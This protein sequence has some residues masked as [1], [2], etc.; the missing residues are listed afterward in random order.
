M[1]TRV[2][3]S[4]M[5]PMS[6]PLVIGL[7]L[8]TTG[9]KAVA[10]DAR[11]QVRGEARRTYPLRMTEKGAA[12]QDAHVVWQAARQALAT[13][14]GQLDHHKPDAIA[15]SGAMHTLLPV[16]DQDQPLA[17]ATT[18]ADSRALEA[19]RQLRTEADPRDLY[20]RTGCPLQTLYHPARLRWWRQRDPAIARRARRWV[21]I[22]DYV[23]H[24]LTGQWRTDVSLAAATGLLN[25]HVGQWDEQAMEHAGLDEAR[26]PQLAE[27]TD[28][29]GHLS[30]AVANATG[31]PRGLPVVAGASDGALS[32]IGAGA[33]TNGQ[34]VINVGTSGAVRIIR[35]APWLDAQQRTWCYLARSGQFL[36]GG[37][38]NNAG[39]AAQ[40]VCDRLFADVE[41]SRRFAVMLEEAA[42]A[43]PGSDGLIW[44]PYF[45][46]ERTP[47]WLPRATASLHGLT[48]RHT[49]GH[50]ARA[51]LEAV[52]YCLA[53]AWAPLERVFVGERALPGGRTGPGAADDG[54]PSAAR[55]TGGITRSRVWL[56]IVA[57]VLRVP[58]EPV[59]IAD[60]SAIG[61]GMLGH[62]ALGHVGGLGAFVR[63]AGAPIAP[64]PR[65][66]AAYARCLERFRALPIARR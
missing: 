44:R 47:H 57:D 58:L 36:I 43:P 41:P 15:L 1:L 29:V 53:D 11:G 38:I 33:G 31:L 46:G 20:Q 37:A 60:A 42:G 9:C 2:I 14:T 21:A 25:I 6:P 51:M 19:C 3:H 26:L 49:R 8:G 55:V 30:D 61:A 23:C 64:D 27:P 7:D 18:W 62:V 22:K 34:P 63:S 52:A 17:A 4:R 16:D 40:W 66:H 5:R 59:D 24:R 45:T 65:N 54:A 35:D 48:P 10:I 32:N 56:Q 28:I 12:E 39:L 13:L 50:M